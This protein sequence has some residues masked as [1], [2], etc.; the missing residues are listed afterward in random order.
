[1]L[2]FP[3][4]LVWSVFDNDPSTYVDLSAFAK[5]KSL[6]VIGLPGAFPPT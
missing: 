6:L 3:S 1:M 4:A 5:E 2:Q